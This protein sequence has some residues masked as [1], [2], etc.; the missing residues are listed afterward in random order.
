MLLDVLLLRPQAWAHIIYNRQNFVW[1]AN[2]IISSSYVAMTNCGARLYLFLLVGIFFVVAISLRETIIPSEYALSPVCDALSIWLCTTDVI[3]KTDVC[4]VINTQITNLW[5]LTTVF[6]Y[7]NLMEF[8][9]LM[10]CVKIKLFVSY[11]IKSRS[12]PPTPLSSNQ[13]LK[14]E[15]PPVQF[16]SVTPPPSY[17]LESG[18]DL[19]TTKSGESKQLRESLDVLPKTVRQK[20][21]LGNSS[22]S[23]NVIQKRLPPCHVLPLLCPFISKFAFI[24]GIIWIFPERFLRLM[25]LYFSMCAGTVILMLT[26]SYGIGI[27]SSLGVLLLEAI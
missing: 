22:L 23:E 21:T 19:S 1:R 3:R 14:W 11:D 24:L 8:I 2:E 20:N 26:G 5:P 27:F 15:S 16:M 25:E 12:I 13:R 4:A 18:G 10:S 7:R 9:W 6:L 17:R